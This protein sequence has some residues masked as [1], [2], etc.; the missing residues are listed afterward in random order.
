MIVAGDFNTWNPTRVEIVARR[1]AAL[2]LVSVLPSVDTRSRFLGR[3]VDFIFVRGLE[4]VHAEAPEVES[5]DHNPVLATLR[6]S[7]APR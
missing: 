4:V 3:Q 2:G 1:D 7:G 6:V 5:S